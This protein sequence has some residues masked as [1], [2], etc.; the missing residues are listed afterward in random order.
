MYRRA[1]L[2]AACAAA[3][4]LAGSGAGLAGKIDTYKRW[5]GNFSTHAFGCPDTTTYGQ[6][7]T[8]PQS[9]M[10]NRFTFWWANDS[11]ANPDKMIVRAEVYAWDGA[12]AT[13]SALWESKPRR[14]SYSD[15]AFHP[16]TFKPG[17]L[18][19]TPGSQ[20]VLFASIDKDFRKCTN[21]YQLRWGVVNG[22]AYGGGSF[23]FHNNGGDESQWTSAP[24][25]VSSNTDL[26]MVAVFH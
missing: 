11:G 22:S 7:I 14:I 26:T 24:W 2:A 4:T 17:A 6:L 12:K 1:L 8:A 16:E 3:F 15:T 25:D 20:Y 21:S 5:D 19:L 23:V 18:P 10:L 9:A 13:G